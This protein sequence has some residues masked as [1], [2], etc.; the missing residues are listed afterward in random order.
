MTV[1]PCGGQRLS[2][3]DWTS[4]DTVLS[5]KGNPFRIHLARDCIGTSVNAQMT[6][7]LRAE[8]ARVAGTASCGKLTVA[9]LFAGRGAWPPVP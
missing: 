6:W 5:V 2:R 1:V 7:V 4:M 3:D 8:A 9:M